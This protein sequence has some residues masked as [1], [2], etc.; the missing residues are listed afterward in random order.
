MVSTLFPVGDSGSVNADRVRGLFDAESGCDQLLDPG[1]GDCCAA[2]P[3]DLRIP[4]GDRLRG[5]ATGKVG[6]VV[7]LDGG[8]GC[9]S[10]AGQCLKRPGEFGRD[11]ETKAQRLGDLGNGAER[12][13]RLGGLQHPPGRRR[14]DLDGTPK[15]SLSEAGG[16]PRVVKRIDDLPGRYSTDHRRPNHTFTTTLE[17]TRGLILF[18]KRRSSYNDRPRSLYPATQCSHKTFRIIPMHRMLGAWQVENGEPPIL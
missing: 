14:L 7:T 15:L 11:R 12:E 1:S 18:Q 3:F 8:E 10:G 5:I 13:I 17:A 2:L 9:C 4:V 6:E 16:P